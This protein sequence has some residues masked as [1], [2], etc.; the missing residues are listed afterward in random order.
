[1][2]YSTLA[3]VTTVLVGLLVSCAT[4]NG[5]PIDGPVLFNQSAH[6]P[7]INFDTGSIMY[8]CKIKCCVTAL[9]QEGHH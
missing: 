3:V 7:L 9:S 1:M 4:G 8:L 5:K 6:N 2:W